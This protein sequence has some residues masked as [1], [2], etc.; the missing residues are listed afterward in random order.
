MVGKNNSFS[1]GLSSNSLGV[2][3]KRRSSAMNSESGRLKTGGSGSGIC[4]APRPEKEERDRDR[5]TSTAK[6]TRQFKADDRAHAVPP[7]R[8]CRRNLRNNGISQ[9]GYQR[10]G[11]LPERQLPDARRP[12]WQTRKLERRLWR[13]VALPTAEYLR[14]SPSIGKAEQPERAVSSLRKIFKP[15][16][17]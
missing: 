17:L 9:S 4:G 11:I 2:P 16:R 10:F 6:F 1:S 5:L 12:A 8:E 14:A 13:K 15:H 7:E 3:F